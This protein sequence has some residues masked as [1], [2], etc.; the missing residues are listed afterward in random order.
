MNANLRGLLP[1]KD[2]YLAPGEVIV[3]HVSRGD[4]SRIV[5]VER[6]RPFDD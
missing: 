4:R 2:P 1:S 6:F 3:C 5:A